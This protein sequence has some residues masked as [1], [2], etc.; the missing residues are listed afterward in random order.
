MSFLKKLVKSAG[1]AVGGA[2]HVTASVALTP[3]KLA[4]KAVSKIPVVGKPLSTVIK[5]TQGPLRLADSIA[6][7][8]RIDSAVIGNIKS[9]IKDVKEVAPYAQMVISVV[10]GVGTVASGAIGAGIALSN[11]QPI[12]KALVAGIKDSIPG[13]AAGKALF[14]VAEAAVSGKPLAQVG[15]AALPLPDDQKKAINSTLSFVKDVAAGKRVDQSLLKAA[16]K[17]LSP[18]MRK[19]L[20]VAVA[21][22]EGKKVQLEM[23]KNVTPAML[24]KLSEQG[25]G[26]VKANAT[27]AAGLKLVPNIEQQKGFRVGAAI[28]DYSI[29]PMELVAIRKKLSPEQQKGFDLA[30]SGRAGM[31]TAPA[32]KNNLNPAASFAYAATHGVTGSSNAIKKQVVNATLKNP[33]AK[34]G[35]VVAA[36][37]IA[38]ENL[39]TQPASITAKR[40][41]WWNRFLA[42][43]SQNKSLAGSFRSA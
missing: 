19:A 8:D 29:N 30:A 28:M 25:A 24:N 26:L 15:L 10:P 32:P 17:N 41:G 11:G 27:L 22:A 4:G 2:V 37:Q 18:D 14:S 38:K 6:K 21:V 5:I 23:L 35:T 16:E 42:R 43:V 12:T 33:D 40:V 13:G 39:A 1:K 20:S 36:T 9:Q 7:G 3:G 34:A 31:A